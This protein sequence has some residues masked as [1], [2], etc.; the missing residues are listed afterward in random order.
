MKTIPSRATL[1]LIAATFGAAAHAAPLFLGNSFFNVPPNSQYPIVNNQLALNNTSF[2]IFVAGPFDVFVPAGPSSGTLLNYQVKR[3]LN[4]A[5]GSQLM[6][7]HHVARRLVPTAFDRIVRADQRLRHQL[8]GDHWP[9]RH[10]PD[11]PDQRRRDLEHQLRRPV[12]QLRLR[13]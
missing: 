5:F 3:Q 11:Q 1:V 9:A 6:N 12:I 2:G 7:P 4:P 10:H 13:D 8:P